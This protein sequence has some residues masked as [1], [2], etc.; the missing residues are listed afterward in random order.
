MNVRVKMKMKMKMR[1]LNVNFCETGG[2]KQDLL[3]KKS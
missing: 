1:G 2:G 3:S